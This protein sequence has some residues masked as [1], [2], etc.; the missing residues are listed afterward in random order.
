MDGGTASATTVTAETNT[1][2]GLINR[3]VTDLGT[4]TSAASWVFTITITIT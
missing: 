3:K 2:P 1:T 4:K